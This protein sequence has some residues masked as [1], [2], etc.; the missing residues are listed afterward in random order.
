MMS[1]NEVIITLQNGS[2][3]TY[4]IFDHAKTD[5]VRQRLSSVYPSLYTEAGF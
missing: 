1:H 5:S 3:H 4:G 2:T